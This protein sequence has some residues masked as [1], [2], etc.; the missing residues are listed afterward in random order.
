[1]GGGLAGLPGRRRPAGE[2]GAGGEGVGVVGAQHP[3]DV[4]EQVAEWAAARRA[5]RPRPA[6][7]ELGAGGEGVGVVGAQHP[8]D[9]GEQVAVGA[10]ARPGLPGLARHGRGCRGW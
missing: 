7:G 9:V 4:G 8:Q 1:M 6:M 5:A 10:A 2:L 3:Q